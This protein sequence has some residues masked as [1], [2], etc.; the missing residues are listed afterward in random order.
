MWFVCSGVQVQP[1]AIGSDC[2]YCLSF[3][4]TEERKKQ[5]IRSQPEL[6]YGIRR[7]GTVRS[8]AKFP[9]QEYILRSELETQ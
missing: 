5:E 9:H 7:H 8:A 3:A 4:L 2:M 6:P 1:L